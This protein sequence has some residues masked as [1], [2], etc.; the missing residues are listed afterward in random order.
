MK[1]KIFERMKYDKLQQDFFKL[2]QTNNTSFTDNNTNIE[3][4]KED[5]KK[6]HFDI[7]FDTYFAQSQDDTQII[8]ENGN[9]SQYGNAS[10]CI[11]AMLTDKSENN[12]Y[13]RIIEFYTFFL[14]QF[15]DIQDDKKEMDKYRTYPP[16]FTSCDEKTPTSKVGMNHHH[17][18]LTNIY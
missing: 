15:D 13:L 8:N 18:Y 5:F 6:N 16:L 3:A 7:P 10:G 2:A 1:N 17:L 4:I 12:L 9:I 14:R 11:Y